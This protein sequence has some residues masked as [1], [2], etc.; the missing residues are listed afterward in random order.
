MGTAQR[1]CVVFWINPESSITE[2]KYLNGHLQPISQTIQ[3]EED[4]L[5]TA[6]ETGTNS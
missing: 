6:K 3:D 5:V 1:D 4:M 2:E